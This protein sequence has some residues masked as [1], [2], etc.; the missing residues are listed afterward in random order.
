V[1]LASGDEK[2]MKNT[3]EPPA[4]HIGDSY[5]NMDFTPAE[6]EKIKSAHLANNRKFCPF[7]LSGE[8]FDQHNCYNGDKEK[9]FIVHQCIECKG[10]WKYQKDFKNLIFF[11]LPTRITLHNQRDLLISQAIDR[12]RQHGDNH[13]ADRLEKLFKG[14]KYASI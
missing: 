12:L 3:C 7:C 9:R 2:T 10:T 8:P 14:V 11:H 13:F 1:R 4:I 6:L 5:C